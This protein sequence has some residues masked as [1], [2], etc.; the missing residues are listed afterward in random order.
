MSST[1][2]PRLPTSTGRPAVGHDRLQ[3][4]WIMPA[5]SDS[6]PID[7]PHA[8]GPLRP[9]AVLLG[10]SGFRSRYPLGLNGSSFRRVALVA[11]HR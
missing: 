10:V 9:V 7:L 8:E 3:L 4:R 11:A 5:T 2:P 6:S 1:L